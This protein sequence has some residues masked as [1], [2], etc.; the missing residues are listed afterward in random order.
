[1]R[2]SLVSIFCALA[3]GV[4][5]QVSDPVVMTI[6]GQ[7]VTRS[8]FEYSYNKNNSDEVID[9]TTVEQYVPLF[10]NYKLKVQA[11]LDAKLDT[12]ESFR[13]E[14]RK[15]RD[16]QV[17]PTM[18]TADDVEREAHAIYDERK[19]QIGDK[20]LVRPAH[21]L[22]RLSQKASKGQQDSVHQRIDSI[23]NCVVKGQD[24]A[25]LAETFSQDPGSAKKGGQLP[26][27]CI[28]QTLKEFEDVA[29]ALKDGE[30]SQPVLSP[31]GWHIIKM[32]G[33][34]QLEPF[35]SL[36]ANII[37]FIERRNLRDAIARRKIADIVK[38]SGG[39]VTA[40][41]VMQQRSDS[42]ARIDQQ[43]KYLIQ[44]YHDGLLL[45]EISTRE[46]WDKASKDT[47]GIVKFY[48]KN[49]KKLYKK[50][51]LEEVMA[52]VV[53]DYQDQM[54]RQWVDALRRR[55]D[56]SID[57]EVLKTVNNHK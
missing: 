8:E 54:E 57:E 23:Y 21:I 19:K 45:F 36:R 14:F 37:T 44:E 32:T 28:G 3:I 51:K 47:V 22:L 53:T 50:K 43:M 15:Y 26:W 16:Q 9:K 1:M 40:D 52:Q 11:A 27:I 34:K 20:G 24:F 38:S 31:V 4:G 48:K 17:R 29:F 46:V 6:N 41:D 49:R 42:I 18:V 2:K 30:V 33:H 25:F 35:D 12:M 10:V 55:Y 39:K 56:V 13:K 7:K 5:A